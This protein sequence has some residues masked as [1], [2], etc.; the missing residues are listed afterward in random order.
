MTH[1]AADHQWWNR[2]GERAAALPT[3]AV[4]EGPAPKRE[5]SVIVPPMV[6]GV[7]IDLILLTLVAAALVGRLLFSADGSARKSKRNRA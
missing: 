5:C 2:S 6:M 3:N 4:P 7:S 1:R